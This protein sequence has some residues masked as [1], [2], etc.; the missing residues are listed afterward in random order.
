MLNSMI[1]I[2]A[3]K[4]VQLVCTYLQAKIPAQHAQLTA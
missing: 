3:T 2:T 1:I 4:L